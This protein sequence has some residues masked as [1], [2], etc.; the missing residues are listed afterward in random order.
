MLH[1]VLDGT[2]LTEIFDL[3]LCNVLAV[4]DVQRVQTEI[5]CARE[6]FDFARKNLKKEK[7]QSPGSR[8]RLSECLFCNVSDGSKAAWIAQCHIGEHF[9][10]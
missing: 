8:Q 3:K 9:A 2:F 6:R 10:V 5:A 4:M 7:S 1:Q